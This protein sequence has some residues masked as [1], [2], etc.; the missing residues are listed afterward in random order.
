MDELTLRLLNRILRLPGRALLV[1][2]AGGVAVGWLSSSGNLPER[3]VQLSLLAAWVAVARASAERVGP[4]M[5]VVLSAGLARRAWFVAHLAAAALFAA[6]ACFAVLSTH[7]LRAAF[8]AALV[9]LVYGWVVGTIGLFAVL[10][11]RR[12]GETVWIGGILLALILASA[13]LLE[14]EAY[15]A[16][17][18]WHPLYLFQY[19]IRRALALSSISAYASGFRIEGIIPPLIL[20][21]IAWRWALRSVERL[22]IV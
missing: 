15:G 19:G 21:F 22:E 5:A 2:L 14:T 7:G 4:F 13:S 20:S 16:G 17:H 12:P 11:S 6:G 10:R 1:A 3:T 18:A 8:G 9:A